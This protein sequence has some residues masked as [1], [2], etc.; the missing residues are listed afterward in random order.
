MEDNQPIN[1]PP[2][3]PPPELANRRKPILLFAFL[4]AVILL[5]VGFI[6][7]RAGENSSNQKSSPQAYTVEIT[8][9]GFVPQTLD[10]PTGSTVK[11]VNK[12]NDPYRIAANPQPSHSSFPALDSKDPIGPDG[13]YSFKFTK[14]GTIVYNNHF[15]PTEN[16]G[17]IRVEDA[18]N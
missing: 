14:T 18:N 10:V 11:W 16:N 15:K 9:D 7:L 13:E 6:M 8:N 17:E 1:L 3:Y 4:V 2:Q 12:T 5:I